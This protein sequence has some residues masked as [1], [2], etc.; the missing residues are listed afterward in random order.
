VETLLNL[1]EGNKLKEFDM[2]FLCNWLGK[3]AKGRF[4]KADEQAKRLGVKMYTTTSRQARKIRMNDLSEQH[5]LPGINQWPLEKLT[6]RPILKPLQNG[7]DG[8]RI[9]R[10]LDLYLERFLVGQQYPPDVRLHS[11]QLSEAYSYNFSDTT[12]EYFDLLVGTIPEAT[13][14]VTGDHIVALMLQMEKKH[15]SIN[16]LW[17]V[18]VLIQL[19][20][21]LVA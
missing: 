13:S 15:M 1:L 10:T 8:T 21:L 3:K 16:Y 20:I 17:W 5:Y 18:T 9:I 11:E 7:M 4:Y 19:L 12:G 14:G 6:K 2:T